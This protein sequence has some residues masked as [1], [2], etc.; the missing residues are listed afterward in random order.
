MHQRTAPDERKHARTASATREVSLSIPTDNPN[1]AQGPTTAAGKIDN[2][3]TSHKRNRPTRK[4]DENGT[5]ETTTEPETDDNAE[6][7]TGTKVQR[8]A[9]TTATETTRNNQAAQPRAAGEDEI[10]TSTD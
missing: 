3:G 2:A 1:G 6:T 8:N 9:Q 5:T 7:A 10:P 4:T